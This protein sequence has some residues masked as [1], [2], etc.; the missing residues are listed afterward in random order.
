MIDRPVTS[1]TSDSQ[2]PRHLALGAGVLAAR[3][4]RGAARLA[5]APA[6]FAAPFAGALWNSRP[7]EPVRRNVVREARAVARIGAR[8]ELMLRTRLDTERVVG[9]VLER[10]ELERAITAALASP[11]TD[12]LVQQVLDSPEARR[13]LEWVANSD[14]VRAAIARQS[15]G[16]GDMVSREI[17]G[18]GASA[19]DVAERLARGVLRRRPRRGRD[20]SA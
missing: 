11:G 2:A 6:R 18:R 13:V 12:R 20:P 5:F 16:L 17:R 7:L 4:T 14:E 15:A 10:P 19:D 3:G 1:T 9:T 8:E